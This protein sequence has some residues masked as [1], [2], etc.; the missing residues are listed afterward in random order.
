M[1]EVYR[2][3]LEGMIAR[4]WSAPRERVSVSRVRLLGVIL[5]Y[6]LI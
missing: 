3:I 2:S 4:G 6:A 1:G 5:R